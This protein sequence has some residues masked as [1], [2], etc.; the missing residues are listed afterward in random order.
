M[1]F[2][3]GGQKN[4]GEIMKVSLIIL[5]KTNVEKMSLYCLAIMLLKARNIQAACHYVDE[6]IRDSSNHTQ[7]PPKEYRSIPSHYVDEMVGYRV[8]GYL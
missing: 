5:L 1:S 3:T 4:G 2:V 7:K 8:R 6:T